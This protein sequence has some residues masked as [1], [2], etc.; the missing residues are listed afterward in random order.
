M[1]VACVSAESEGE[2]GM[3]A[4]KLRGNAPKP[5]E[6]ISAASELLDIRLVESHIRQS[7]KEGPMPKHT[8][9]G[10]TLETQ[11]NEESDIFRVITT[12]NLAISYEE[13]DA[14]P[15]IGVMA[16]F[17]MVFKLHDSKLATKE[18]LGPFAEQ[19]ALFVIWPY[20]REQVNN[21]LGRMG[22][23]PFTVPL[24]QPGIL[25]GVDS[26]E[27]KAATKHVVSRKKT[28]R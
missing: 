22:L 2:P 24:L 11:T 12:F 17:Q 8:S 10:A 6:K 3:K 1:A 13:G 4:K 14:E 23:P 26:T 25:E 7:I 28:N 21:S 15:A 20:W 5:L 27:Q 16:R 9:L 19:I 18:L